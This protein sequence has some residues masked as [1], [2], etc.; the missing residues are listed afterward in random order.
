M[1]EIDRERPG[2]G[3]RL[4]A[5]PDPQHS[6]AM[7]SLLLTLCVIALI[8]CNADYVDRDAPKVIQAAQRGDLEGVK[9]F[10]ADDPSVLAVTDSNG[11][12]AT[13]WAI[14]NDHHEIAIYLIESGYP[15]DPTDE[16]EFPLI[17]S[18]LSRYTPSSEAMLKYLLE[19]G[20]DPNVRYAPEGWVALNMAVNNGMENKARLLV[21]YG[22]D[23][24]SKDRLGQTSLELAEQRVAEFKNPDFNY[25]HG[26]LNDPKIRQDAIDRWESM[27][28][29]LTELVDGT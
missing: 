11:N 24:G 21:K 13:H 9:R 17:M 14:L 27:V 5:A 2:R 1:P 12:S 7:R 10:L 15:I 22:A 16:S 20:A 3:R 4:M 19:N 28:K 25:P 23:L 26:E 29:L 6:W 18:C 8:G